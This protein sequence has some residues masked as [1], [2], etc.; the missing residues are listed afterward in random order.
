MTHYVTVTV[1]PGGV[2]D[3]PFA[4]DYLVIDSIECSVPGGCGEWQVC[5]HP[6]DPYDE[7]DPTFD[8]EEWEFHGVLHEW[9]GMTW[10]AP[11]RGCA[12]AEW[13]DDTS[14]LWDDIDGPGRY[15]VDD[16]WDDTECYLTVVRKVEEP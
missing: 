7:G 6:E 8:V 5:D 9:N 2:P 12:V 4:W 3:G 15:E 16:D 11:F 10:V 1:D 14:T 13:G